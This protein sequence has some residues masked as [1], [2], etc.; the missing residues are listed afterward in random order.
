[1]I[2]ADALVLHLNPLQEALQPEGQCDFSDLVPKMA[3]VAAALDVP[4]VV[5]EIGC[6][7]SADAGR[8]LRDAGLTILDTAGLGGTSWARIEA[9]RADDIELGELFANWGVSTPRSIR[10]LR[11]LDGVTVIASGGVRNGIDIAKAIALGGDV[12]GLAQPFLAVAN[13]SADR[14]VDKTRR[15]IRE[16]EIAMFCVGARTVS[17]L[18]QVSLHRRDLAS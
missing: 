11:R 1:M 4:V 5:K 6:G 12:V 9:K 8:R 18:Q 15:L 16:L 10:A 13:D 2:D 14:T 7:L 17:E 3:A